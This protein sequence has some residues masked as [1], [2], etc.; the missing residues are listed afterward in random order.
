[1]QQQQE[2][3]DFCVCATQENDRDDMQRYNKFKVGRRLL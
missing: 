2:T 3:W 1:M